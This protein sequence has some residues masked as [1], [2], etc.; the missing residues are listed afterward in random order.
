MVRCTGGVA[1]RVMPAVVG[2]KRLFRSALEPC[3]T[4]CCLAS[5]GQAISVRNKHRYQSGIIFEISVY[6]QSRRR[7]DRKWQEILP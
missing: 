5:S 2:S 3:R 6:V 7:A 4:G 1:R